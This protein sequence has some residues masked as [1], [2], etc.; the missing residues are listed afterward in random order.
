MV[1]DPCDGHVF[2]HALNNR[3]ASLPLID[4]SESFSTISSMPS[5]PPKTMSICLNGGN[6]NFLSSTVTVPRSEVPNL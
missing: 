3:F 6:L 1:R 4:I 2:T 5:T